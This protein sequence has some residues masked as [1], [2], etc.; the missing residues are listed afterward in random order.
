MKIFI[1][2]IVAAALSCEAAIVAGKLEAPAPASAAA[3]SGAPAPAAASK[4]PS[5]K[6]LHVNF[7][8]KNFNYYDL[9]KVTCPK[10]VKVAKAKAKKVKK[11]KAKVGKKS[12]DDPMEV[13]SQDVDKAVDELHAGSKAIAKQM[14]G[15]EPQPGGKKQGGVLPWME[16]KDAVLLQLGA[17]APMKDLTESK[18]EECTTIMDVLRDAIKDTVRGVIACLHAESQVAVASAPGPAPAFAALPVGEVA[19]VAGAPAGASGLIPLPPQPAAFLQTRSSV[20]T[21]IYPYIPAPAP[22]FA[23][24]GAPAGPPKGPEVNIFVT[25]KPGRKMEGGKSTLVEVTFLDQPNNG[26][27]DIALAMPL[28]Q[29]SIHSGFFKRMIKKALHAVTGIHPQIRGLAMSMKKIQQWDVMK[30]ENH[31]KKIVGQFSMHYTRNQVPMALYNECTNFMTKMSFSHDYVLDP[32]DTLRCR[33]ATAKF[34]KKWNYGENAEGSDFEDMCHIACEAKYGR[35]A[36]TCNIQAGDGLLNQ[37][38]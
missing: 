30:C 8:I 24:A 29:S 21:N 11:M 33:K 37:P 3:P 15:L 31:I 35:N 16:K 27:N 19:E 1:I 20:P 12:P 10:K 4:L 38:L 9:T 13:A 7:E 36:P 17:C 28:I 5:L 25:F 23:P 14:S 26:V 34:Q 2:S 18:T 32:Q 6:A 22:A